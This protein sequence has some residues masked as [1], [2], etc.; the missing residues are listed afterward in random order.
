MKI[1]RLKINSSVVTFNLGLF[2]V[3]AGLYLASWITGN[4][5]ILTDIFGVE[6]AGMIL[7]ITNIATVILRN[8]NQQ[9]LKPIEV[10]P[11]ATKKE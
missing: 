5:Q 10:L 1:W 8:T 2:L 6:T 3:T 11:S 9:G 7:M 4:Q